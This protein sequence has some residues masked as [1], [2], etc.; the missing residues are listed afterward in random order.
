[1]SERIEISAELVGVDAVNAGFASMSLA[2]QSMATKMRQVDLFGNTVNKNLKETGANLKS[3]SRDVMIF[4]TATL[5]I[6]RLGEA[7]GFLNDEQAKALSLFGSV[8]SVGA[9]VVR[10]IDLMTSATWAATTASW[11]HT[12][13]L[14][15][16]AI[17]LAI[18]NSL[19]PVGWGILAGAAVAATAGLA[20]A[21]QI[22]TAH[23][24]DT[25]V[26]QSGIVSVLKDEHILTSN[27]Y[28]NLTD[29]SAK[30][31]NVTINV[32]GGSAENVLEALRRTGIKS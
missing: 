24:G 11:A 25:R 7:F 16:K 18:V 6:S 20:M 27:Q 12:I 1:M 10:V 15:A 29:R 3:L 14:K 26:M 17:A 32:Y 19:S 8:I 9:S 22:P 13:A 2:S 23:T 30:T 28:S 5:G 4:G 31:N 21:N